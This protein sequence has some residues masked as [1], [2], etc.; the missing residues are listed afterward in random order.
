M[1][2]DK[3]DKVREAFNVLNNGG[4][5]K[6]QIETARNIL[7]EALA[8]DPRFY[9]NQPVLVRDSDD[10]EWE[11]KILGRVGDMNLSFPFKTTDGGLYSRCKPDPDAES[12]INWIEH[13]GS[14][15]VVETGKD[16]VTMYIHNTIGPI[17]EWNTDQ[18]YTGTNV[19]RYAI[20]PLPEYL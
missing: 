14:E 19:V 3:E 2:K 5:D 13:D 11:S 18:F 4:G 17:V 20:I 9:K 8:P 16:K 12:I 1:N 6:Y 7:K 10:S 15:S